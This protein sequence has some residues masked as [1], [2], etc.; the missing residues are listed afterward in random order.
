MDDDFFKKNFQKIS[1]TPSCF[2]KLSLSQKS[3]EYFKTPSLDDKVRGP[4][5]IFWSTLPELKHYVI[6]DFIYAPGIWVWDMKKKLPV[7]HKIFHA[8]KSSACL[9]ADNRSIAAITS[10]GDGYILEIPS[11]RVREKFKTTV[12]VGVHPV[13]MSPSL[14]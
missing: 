6:I 8:K 10:S 2:A 13:T 1:Y 11:L 3:I 5:N 7:H 9:C 14:A 4:F 12:P